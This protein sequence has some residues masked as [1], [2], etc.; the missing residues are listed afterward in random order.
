MPDDPE[1]AMS[2]LMEDLMS[3]VKPPVATQEQ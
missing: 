2:V 1:K 3:E